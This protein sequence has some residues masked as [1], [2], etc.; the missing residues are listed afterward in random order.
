MRRK[1]TWDKLLLASVGAVGGWVGVFIMDERREGSQPG[2][3]QNLSIY[4]PVVRQPACLPAPSHLCKQPTHPH[5]GVGK[6]LILLKKKKKN[7]LK[8]KK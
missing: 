2:R 8:L 4:L 7:C 5:W 6:F 1:Q 3:V